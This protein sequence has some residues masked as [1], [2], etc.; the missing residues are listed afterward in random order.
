MKKNF[1]TY[2]FFFIISILF[3]L[4]LFNKDKN[5]T[6]IRSLVA[7]SL[8]Y[9]EKNAYLE[10]HIK[11]KLIYSNNKISQKNNNDYLVYFTGKSC[12]SCAESLLLLL[13]DQYKLLVD[14]INIFIDSN[15]KKEFIL[16]LNDGYNLNY[17]YTLNKMNSLPNCNDILFFKLDNDGKVIN[18]I[19]YRPEQK[20]LFKEYF[21]K[22]NF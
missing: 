16:N 17:E 3:G 2:G 10:R 22:F 20:K 13:N 19:E 4:F 1:S 18:V 6:Y 15:D 5:D 11:N 21:K 9:K 12:S 14:N 8:I 7:Q